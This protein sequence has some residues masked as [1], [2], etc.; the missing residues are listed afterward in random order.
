[1]T[2]FDWKGYALGELGAGECRE[3][4]AHAEI[5][6]ECRQE[7]A[8]VRLTLDALSTL[9][10]EEVPRRIAFVSDKVFEPRWWRRVWSPSFAAACVV[11]AA[12]VAHGFA[13][14]PAAPAAPQAD[15]ARI[16]AAV[17]QRVS[18]AL[19]SAVAKAVAE[20]TRRQNQ[21][22]QQ[23]LAASESRDAEQRKAD[24]ATASANFEMVNKMLNTVY[25]AN[26][27]AGVSQ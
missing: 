14:R 8:A 6:L 26:T 7:L 23:A 11:A 9:R 5:C 20:S 24:F 12:I 4:E 16:E 15:E 2:D 25:A 1:M 18:A 13:M 10:E 22:M 27:G 3:A 19:D 17:A 21:Q